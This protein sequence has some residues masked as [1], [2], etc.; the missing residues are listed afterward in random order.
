[1]AKLPGEDFQ[2]LFR[3]LEKKCDCIIIEGSGHPGGRF[4]DQWPNARIARLLDA[5]VLMV[6][7]GGIGN[8]IDSVFM[9]LAL[10]EKE[11]VEVYVILAQQADPGKA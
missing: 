4:G 6:T 2:D 8:V 11:G 3:E 9:N 1:M 10:F 7:G 5:P